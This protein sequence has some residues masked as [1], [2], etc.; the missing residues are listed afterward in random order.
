MLPL[1]GMVRLRTHRSIL[2]RLASAPW[3]VVAVVAATTE[4]ALAAPAAS[5][6]VLTQGATY[7]ARLKLSFFQ[8][9]A[10]RDRIERKLEGGG[11]A[12]VRVFT[13]ARD[14]PEDWPS[15]FRSGAG[16][17][18]RYAEGVWARPTTPRRRP[19]SIE[20]W[21]IATRAPAP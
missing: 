8:C 5:P 19:S 11:F 15:R 4:P 1:T 17:C 10:S 12:G 18:E 3:L 9:L 6:I 13:S 21:W 20:S 7:R 2:S 14:L 16:S